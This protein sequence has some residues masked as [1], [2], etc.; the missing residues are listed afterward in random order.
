MNRYK[1]SMGI[2]PRRAI[3]SN[4][5]IIRKHMIDSFEQVVHIIFDNNESKEGKI[6]ELEKLN[7]SLL[8]QG[9]IEQQRNILTYKTILYMTDTIKE[10]IDNIKMNG[11]IIFMGSNLHY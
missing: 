1:S 2:M 11:D 10:I 7:A 5:H 3:I 6:N 8:Q 4:Q 9:I